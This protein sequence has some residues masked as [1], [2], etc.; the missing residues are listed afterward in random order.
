MTGN[1]G[2]LESVEIM[3]NPLE[4]KVNP[5]FDFT[6]KSMIDRSSKLYNRKLALSDV[7]GKPITYGE[8]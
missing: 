6:L 1:P 4:E 8:M 2:I 7:D 5:P 3:M